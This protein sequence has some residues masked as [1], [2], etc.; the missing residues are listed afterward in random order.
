MNDRL[1]LEE[2]YSRL[3]AKSANAQL[4]ARIKSELFKNQV[5]FVNDPAREKGALCTRRAGKTSMWTRLAR[6]TTLDR[7]RTITRIWSVNRIRAKQLIWD[8]LKLLDKRHG[9]QCIYNETEL[10]ARLP[11]GSEIRLLGADKDKEVQKK[12]GDKTV[13]E[14]VLE[15]QMFGPYLQTLVEDVAGPCLFDLQGTFCLEGTPGPLCAGYWYQVSGREDFA[16]KWTSIGGKDS[17]G[18]GWSMHRWSVLDNPHLPHAKKEL[19]ALK[20]KRRWTD[21]NPTYVREWLGRW[22]NDLGALYYRFD[23]V[24]NTFTLDEL[25]PWGPGWEHTL[26]WDLGFRDDM[27]LVV[28]GWHPNR[29]ELYE[30]FSWKQPGALSAKVVETINGL[31]ARGFNFVKRI[32]DTGGGGK[33]Y[34][35][36]LISRYGMQFDAAKKTD[37]YDHVR[38]FNDDLSGG[39]VK[40]QANSVYAQELSQLPRDQDWPPPEKP[41]AA[42]REDPRFP[43]HCCDAGLYA[44]RGAWHYLH[45]DEPAKPTRGSNEYFRAETKRMEEHVLE[46]ARKKSDWIYG[47]EVDAEWWEIDQ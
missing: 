32:A 22:V 37:K 21:D 34:V 10:T 39:F 9:I 16:S 38:L 31:E 44:Y 42:P 35:E 33:M 28:W 36:D 14:V 40:L 29:P 13:L 45:R 18:A 20:A 25:Q 24:R 43:N 4:I 3:Q 27:A 8:E 17:I 11:N 47:D 15:A 23:P 12:R 26:G 6:I 46:K 30:A 19:A 1:I 7:P 2:Y 41:E 5:D